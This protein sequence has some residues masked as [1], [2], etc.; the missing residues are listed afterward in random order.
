[1]NILTDVFVNE[2]ERAEAARA[3]N[4]A[5]LQE[6]L[7]ARVDAAQATFDA[8]VV[9]WPRLR[10][11][12]GL[13]R[14]PA[15]DTAAEHITWVGSSAIN[16]LLITTSVAMRFP[17]PKGPKP[18]LLIRLQSTD[19]QR[20]LAQGAITPDREAADYPVVLGRLCALL[21]DNHARVQAEIREEAARRAKALDAAE[22]YIGLAK[23]YSSRYER[24]KKNCDRW[25]SAMAKKHWEAHELW[26]IRYLPVGSLLDDQEEPIQTIVVMETPEDII[27][28]LTQF[29]TATVTK[30]SLGGDVHEIEI[31]S[32]IDAERMVFNEHANVVMPYHVHHYA[33]GNIVNIPAHLCVALDVSP[34]IISWPD[35][36]GEIES[37]PTWLGDLPVF[38]I[39]KLTPAEFVETYGEWM[40]G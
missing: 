34:S 11:V 6:R 22:T 35:Y 3:E 9:A 18:D 2:V 25:A 31:P 10:E 39:A 17:I 29:P 33:N 13:K 15:V 20:V 36:L 19:D 28:A 5:A 26:R 32:F 21:L 4:S 8:Y 27:Q 37:A 24:Y 38:G 40:A 1:M 7:Q 23:I 12:L 16:D 30:V 14:E